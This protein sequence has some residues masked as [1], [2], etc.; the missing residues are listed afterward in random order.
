MLVLESSSGNRPTKQR[1]DP[2]LKLTPEQMAIV[3]KYAVEHG[4]VRAIR[5]FNSR[6]RSAQTQLWHADTRVLQKCKSFPYILIK[7]IEPRKFC[8]AELLLFTVCDRIYKNPA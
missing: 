5:S 8:T 6:A 3:A 7:S 4:V 1:R 2:Y